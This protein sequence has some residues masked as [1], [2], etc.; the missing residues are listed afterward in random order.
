MWHYTRFGLVILIICSQGCVVHQARDE[1]PPMGVSEIRVMHSDG[2]P[3]VAYLSFGDPAFSLG[4]FK[5]DANGKTE[6]NLDMVDARLITVTII[7][8]PADPSPPSPK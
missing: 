7:A 5:T 8:T 1:G 4:S 3:A 2:R 6:V